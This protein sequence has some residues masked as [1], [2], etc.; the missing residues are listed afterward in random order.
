MKDEILLHLNDA[1]Q[2]EKL[3]R[4]NK[5]PFKR[6]FGTIYP[7][8][9]GNPLADFW[10]ERLT[11]ETD[12]ISWG[13]RRELFLV[14]VASLLA[15]V[16]AKLPALLNINEEFFYSRNIGFIVFPL[17]TTYFAW[18]NK[19]SPGKIAFIALKGIGPG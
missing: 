2:L 17:L 9:K 13:T 18:K 7:Q 19:L 6:A 10:N 15:G 14:I 1:K 8:I 4:T 5:A 3:Y 16:I 12:E 11:Y